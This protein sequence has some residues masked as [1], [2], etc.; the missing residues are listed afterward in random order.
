[1]QD[2]KKYH[3]EF[4]E[5]FGVKFYHDDYYEDHLIIG[6]DELPLSFTK[7]G[8]KP[9]LPDVKGLERLTHIE[10]LTLELGGITKIQNL[11]DFVQL[12]ALIL[13]RN[14]I[15]KIEGLE[16]LRNLEYLNLE[17]NNINT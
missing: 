8:K 10:G 4:V 15:P 13:S 7:E 11:R 12:R 9:D 14:K 5:I 2:R 1:M 6:P 17:F 16:T 3:K